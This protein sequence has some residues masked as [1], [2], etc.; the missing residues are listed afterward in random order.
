MGVRMSDTIVVYEKGEGV[1]SGPRA[2]WMLNVFGAPNVFLMNGT[3]TKWKQENRPTESGD[4]EEAWINI[5][6][7]DRSEPMPD[8]YDYKLDRTK[9]KGYDE[10]CKI[11]KINEGKDLKDRLKLLDARGSAAH[12]LGHIPSSINIPYHQFYNHDTTF[13]SK[14]EIKQIFEEHGIENPENEKIVN[15]C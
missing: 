2:Y 4:N 5:R 9:L 14:E 12:K 13:K 10:I 8:D 6:E 15:S 3:F 1:L 11:V 7:G